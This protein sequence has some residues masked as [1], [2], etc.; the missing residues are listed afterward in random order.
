M[1]CNSERGCSH[2]RQS[3]IIVIIRSV[4]Q[5]NLIEYSYQHRKSDVVVL[6]LDGHQIATQLLFDATEW[7]TAL[8]W[9]M[10]LQNSDLI[11]AFY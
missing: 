4:P 6:V 7:P 11:K 10:K 9:V 1:C 3:P 8:F 2:H 5:T